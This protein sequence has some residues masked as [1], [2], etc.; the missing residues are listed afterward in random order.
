LLSTIAA[1]GQLQLDAINVVQRTQFLV[2]FSRLG[3]YDVGRLHDMTGPGGELFEYWGHA[4]ALLPVAHHPLFRWRM[5]QSGTY[6]ESP[7]R[8]ARWAAFRE[9]NAEYIDNVFREVRDRGPLTAGQ[10][11]DPRRRDGEWWDRRSFGRVTLEYLFLRGELAGWRTASFER[12]YE[13]PERVIPDEVRALPTPPADEA[14]RQLL[15]IAAR[16]LGVATMRDLAGYYVI[17]PKLARQRVAELVAAGELVEVSVEGWS[18][19]AYTL[20]N[21]RARRPTRATATLLSPFDSLIWDRS[22]A[23]RLFGFDYRIEVYVPEPRRK[24]GYFVLPLLLEDQLVGRFDLKADRKASVLQVRGS[25]VEPGVAVSRVATAAAGEL[26]A[27]REW[28]QLDGM[29]I[30]RRGNLATALRKAAS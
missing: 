25:Y 20:P 12:V 11:A 18:E 16:S 8:I 26:D 19:A 27:L 5:E 30:A 9:A 2:L 21:A 3:A 22:R 23:L 10:L 14:Q 4:V 29:V 15:L 7:T 1:L 6:G 13:L 28:L 17:N 24:Y